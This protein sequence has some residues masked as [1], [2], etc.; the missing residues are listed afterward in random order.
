MDDL[1][2]EGWPN[3]LPGPRDHL[4][5]LGVISLTYGSLESMF[6][7]LFAGATGIDLQHVSAFFQRIPNNSRQDIVAEL[8]ATQPLPDDLKAAIRL[9]CEGVEICAGNR[10]ALMHSRS[11]GIVS[12]SAT[13]HYGFVFTKHSRAGNRLVCT[14][15]LT[16]LKA[17]ADSMN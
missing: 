17:V 10:H 14:P 11:G 4:Y 1:G 3:Y 7:V 9:F 12:I 5:A 8:V 2:L 13:G 15:S 6:E 16:D